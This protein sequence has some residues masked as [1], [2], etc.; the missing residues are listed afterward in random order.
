MTAVSKIVTMGHPVTGE[1]VKKYQLKYSD[2]GSN[3]IDYKED[4][5][6]RDTSKVCT[7]YFL[8]F[9][10]CDDMSDAWIDKVE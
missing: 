3:W 10:N 6:D 2:N 7:S 5:S 1:Y 9:G 4:I 8:C